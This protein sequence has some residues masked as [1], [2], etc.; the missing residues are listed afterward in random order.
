MHP[1]SKPIRRELAH[2]LYAMKDYSTS[3]EEFQKLYDDGDKN[4]NT[5]YY[6]GSLLL[7]ENSLRSSI[8]AEKALT[9]AVEFSQG[10]TP[11]ILSDLAVAKTRL[12]KLNEAIALIEEA[13]SMSFRT[14]D[15]IFFS[16]QLEER[17]AQVYLER[18]QWKSSIK[19]LKRAYEIDPTNRRVLYMIARTYRKLNDIENEERYLNELIRKTY[20]DNTQEDDWTNYAKS[21]LETIKETRFMEAK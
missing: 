18:Q 1:K 15:I 7:R 2:T 13:D 10:G 8:R 4:I 19:Y 9:E 14:P 6:L 17:R 3:Q 5:L 11:I 12:K 21:R 16:A 20:N